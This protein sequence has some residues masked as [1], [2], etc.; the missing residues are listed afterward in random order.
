MPKSTGWIVTARPD[1]LDEVRRRLEAV[2]FHVTETTGLNGEVLIGT[3]P[4]HAQAALQAIEGV[5]SVEPNRATR[6]S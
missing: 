4:E 2:D 6:L 5:E 1:R 3:A